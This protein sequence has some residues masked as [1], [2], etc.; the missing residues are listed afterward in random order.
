MRALPS[1]WLRRLLLS[2]GLATLF[3][4][5]PYQVYGHT[6][7][8]RMVHLRLELSS[9]RHENEGLRVENARLRAEVQLYDEDALTAIERVARDELGLVKPGEL[10]FKVEPR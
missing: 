7:L 4:W 3:G 1:P 9:L 8:S 5:V 6:G 10:V 2:C